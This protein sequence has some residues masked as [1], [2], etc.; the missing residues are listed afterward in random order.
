MQPEV[1][2]GPVTYASISVLVVED[3]EHMMRLLKAM[4][5]A[6]GI[7]TVD[8]AADAQRA[9]QIMRV[10][11]PDILVVDW[12]MEG[13]SGIEL[14]RHIRTS[15]ESPNPYMP[16][17]MVTAHAE[18]RLVIEARNAGV[19]EFL[20][21]PISAVTLAQRL[22]AIIDRPRPFVRAA[23]YFGPDRR[24]QARTLKHPE[25]RT[26][27]A[28]LVTPQ[29]MQRFIEERRSKQDGNAA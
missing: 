29:E 7:G 17:M 1:M 24:R 13:M 22:S 12:M 26:A 6:L 11:V 2:A 21:K 18:K 5:R 9:L 15:E 20:A 3:N 4:L 16:I 23:S 27:S 8:T 25:R 14:T 19:S 10:H 28:E